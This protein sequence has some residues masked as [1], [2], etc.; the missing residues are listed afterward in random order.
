MLKV[1]EEVANQRRRKL[2]RAGQRER[3]RPSKRA[4]VLCD[5]SFYMTNI[6]VE[7]NI[8]IKELLA[9]Y[10]IR[11]SIELYFR[12]FKSVLQVHKTEV[13][14]NPHR[15]QCEI[16]GK[17]IVALF[18]SYCYSTTRAHRWKIFHEE[19]SFEKTVKCFKRHISIFIDRLY[20]SIV[21]AVAFIQELIV[22]IYNTCQKFRQKSRQNSLDVLVERSIYNG[23]G[24]KKINMSKIV[25]LI[26]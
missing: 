15:L 3:Y 5:W 18:I 9:L 17:A 12:Q 19:I 14:S 11:W 22:K 6:P 23:L 21:K 2:R 8:D 7:K 10:P 24:Y 26:A 13:K 16:L 1:P 4:L 20:S 25:G